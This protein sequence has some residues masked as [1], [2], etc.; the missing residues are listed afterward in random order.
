MT[1][2][3]ALQQNKMILAAIAIADLHWPEGQQRFH[4]DDIFKD[5]QEWVEE[6][7]HLEAERLA[8]ALS[9]CTWGQTARDEGQDH[10]PEDTEGYTASRGAHTVGGGSGS[11]SKGK[12]KQW[13]M[14]KEDELTDN[15][16][17][18]E[19]KGEGELGPSAKGF[20]MTGDDKPCKM[21]AQANLM[22]IRKPESSCKQCQKAKRKCSCSHGVGRKQKNSST[23]GEAGPS[24]KQVKSIMTLKLENGSLI[25][26]PHVL[27]RQNRPLPP[28]ILLQPL[29]SFFHGA[30]PTP[31]PLFKPSPA[32][33]DEPGASLLINKPQIES[34]PFF[35]TVT[36]LLE[37]PRDIE[38][39]AWSNTPLTTEILEVE[40]P[41]EWSTVNI[42]ECLQV[43]EARAEDEEFELEQVYQ[44]LEMLARWVTYW[45]KT[46]QARWEE[47]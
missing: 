47:L 23:I 17:D 11:A 31:G 39:L 27:L 25:Q 40:Y 12:G 32:P 37:E 20:C 30:T 38:V 34:E 10:A 8:K 13:A 4:V 16:D 36:S 44:L 19:G 1:E 42:V 9:V 7:A 6:R 41:H 26:L 43:L 5:Y 15:I 14:S 45:I 21:C 33:V 46:A 29:I 3:S 2:E 22:C 18:D 28:M 35:V 24:H